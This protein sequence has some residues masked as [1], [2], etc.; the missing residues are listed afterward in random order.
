M[1]C[2]G[3]QELRSEGQ[4]KKI[5]VDGSKN[6]YPQPCACVRMD[7]GGGGGSCVRMPE[8]GGGR[9]EPCAHV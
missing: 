4:I 3:S 8:N 5:M 1:G 7:G 2:A 6:G 9:G